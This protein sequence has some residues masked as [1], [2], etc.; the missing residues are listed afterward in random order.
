MVK[1]MLR[2]RGQI[3]FVKEKKDANFVWTSFCD[4]QI[5]KLS[6]KFTEEKVMVKVYNS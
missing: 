2:K 3:D 5:S 6:S 4:Y 1:E